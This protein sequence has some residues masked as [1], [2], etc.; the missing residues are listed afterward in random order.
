MLYKFS[1]YKPPFTSTFRS[2]VFTIANG[3]DAPL[4]VT[5]QQI[6]CCFLS[7]QT[8]L[9][10][11]IKKVL[12]KDMGLWNIPLH[13]I[14]DD[15][16][17]IPLHLQPCNKTIL[18]PHLTN[19]WTEVL[20]GGLPSGKKLL[21]DRGF[22]RTEVDQWLD[23]CTHCLSLAC[24][25]I[26]LSTG[27]ANFA[28]L[29][30]Q[31][32]SGQRRSI[33]LLK[34]GILAFMNPSTHIN[35]NAALKLIGVTQELSQ[36]L[37][38]LLLVIIPIS[39]NMRRIR[40]QHHP[41][42]LTH[43]WVTYH[44]RSNGSG[45]R[46]LFNTAQLNAELEAVS[47][48]TIGISLTSRNLYHMV[49]GVLRKEFPRLFTVLGQD[50]LSPVDDAAQHRYQT[51]VA[52]YGRLTVFPKS[53]HLIGDHPWRNLAICQL[54]Q[55]SLGCTTVKDAWKELLENSSLFTHLKLQQDVSFQRARE[56]VLYTYKILSLPANERPV[57]A[58]SI[59][60][61]APFIKVRC[62]RYW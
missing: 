20:H 13:L 11:A 18:E 17:A 4:S 54:W 55:A 53:P 12:P 46:W 49:F 31:Q 42:A 15:Y 24:A 22:N 60:Q 57:H 58:N 43:V 59:L 21:G 39:V 2:G 16:S 6:R 32:Y 45:D 52:N 26:F 1:G 9:L 34:D 61:S 27:G 3:V 23:D 28:L 8:H 41:Y 37:L 10:D 33:F 44:K 56:E 19:C 29:R 62:I 50:F 47:K 25:P 7:S 48:D 35:G 38:L 40:G 30:H 14:Q 5:L 36:Y 51:G